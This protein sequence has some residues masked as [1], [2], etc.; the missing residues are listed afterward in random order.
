MKSDYGVD[1]Q[2][3]IFKERIPTGLEFGVQN[4]GTDN[5]GKISNGNIKFS[6][7]TKHLV[8][9]LKLP[10]PILLHRY[11]A[12]NRQGYWLN[13]TEYCQNILDKKKPKWKEQKTVSCDIPISNRLEDLDGILI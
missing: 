8:D 12:Q 11:D 7:K 5:I 1:Y 10:Y 9:Y 4:K 3:Q 6:M 13:L 2:V